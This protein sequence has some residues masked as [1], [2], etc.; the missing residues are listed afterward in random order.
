MGKSPLVVILIYET[1]KSYTLTLEADDGDNTP[2]TATLIINVGD[3]NDNQP[4]LTVCW[5]GRVATTTRLRHGNRYGH[6]FLRLMMLIKERA[7]I[8]L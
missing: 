2:A 4:T 8:L 7:L 1:T 5:H 3:I 6:Q